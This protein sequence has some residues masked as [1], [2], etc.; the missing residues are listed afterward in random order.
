[1][2]GVGTRLLT[3]DACSQIG[4]LQILRKEGVALRVVDE[5]NG[6]VTIEM[7]EGNREIRQA[8]DKGH[9]SLTTQFEH[10]WTWDGTSESQ[11]SGALT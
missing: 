6:Y 3:D 9:D 4:P 5:E 11:R 7:H 8:I 2:E 10:Q 1:M